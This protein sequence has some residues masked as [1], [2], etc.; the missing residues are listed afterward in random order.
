MLLLNTLMKE[1]SGEPAKGSDAE[2]EEETKQMPKDFKPNNHEWG[3]EYAHEEPKEDRHP[4]RRR[5]AAFE[6]FKEEMLPKMR[7]EH[8]GLKR[9]QYM[10]RIFK[11]ATPER[12]ALYEK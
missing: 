8:P 12:L 7:E 4:E 2:E 11:L 6:R 1:T 5:K 10:E 3:V 9:S